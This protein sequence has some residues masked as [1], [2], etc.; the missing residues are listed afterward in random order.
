MPLTPVAAASSRVAGLFVEDEPERLGVEP[1]AGEDRDVLA[2]LDVAGGPAAAEVVVVHRREVVV[3]EAVRVDELERGGEREDVLRVFFERGGGGE[4]EH[5]TD[6]LAAGEEAVAHGFL[7]ALRSG[8]V[9][10]LEVG[11]VA[12]D[13]RA[14]VLGVDGAGGGGAHDSSASWPARA[15]GDSS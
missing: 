2:E 5:G 7:E 14:Q 8:L 1:V 11:E 6:A 3:D 15:G 4:R 10:E 9:G 13:L 12:L